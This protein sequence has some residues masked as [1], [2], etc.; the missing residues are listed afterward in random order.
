MSIGDKIDCRTCEFRA[1][2]EEA[3]GKIDDDDEDCYVVIGTHHCR[4]TWK[5]FYNDTE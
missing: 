5:E 2:C 4:A 3:F 1:Q